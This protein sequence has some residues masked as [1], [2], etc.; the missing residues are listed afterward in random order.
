VN[1][2][3][4]S[5]GSARPAGYSLTQLSEASG[6]APRT[7]RYYQ[8]N[9]LLPKPG[10][11]GNRAV[12]SELHLTRLA[13]IERLQRDGLRL[14]AI[15]RLADSEG[16]AGSAVVD[17][18]GPE[19]AGAAWLAT[20]ARTLTEGELAEMLGESYPERVSELVAAGFLEL[21]DG[22]TPN[23]KMWFAPS[24]PQLKG[25]ME[26]LKLGTGISLSGEA[27][28][29]L[30]K[31]IR[32]VCEELVALWI[33]EAGKGYAGEAT[34]AE[35]EEHLEE[36]RSVAWQSAAHLTAVEMERAIR[37]TDKIRSRISDRRERGTQA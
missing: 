22:P 30:R 7:I 15:R 26:L 5:R 11:R 3:P 35:F 9:G 21:R 4:A 31:R 2:P 29:L 27:T 32:R 1:G 6:V 24:I 25:A 14:Q 37:H 12:Y 20:S 18:L 17:L 23:T 13:S 16:P 33:T 10:R 28:R 8:S 19:M 36:F 34:Q